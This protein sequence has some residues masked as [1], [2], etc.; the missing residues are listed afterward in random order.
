MGYSIAFLLCKLHLLLPHGYIDFCNDVLPPPLS[1][2]NS[3]MVSLLHFEFY[4]LYFFS[5]LLVTAYEKKQYLCL[6]PLTINFETLTTIL[7]LCKKHDEASDKHPFIF[8]VDCLI[9][10]TVPLFPI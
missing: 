2:Q 8:E 3:P 1:N 4:L 7:P 5:T 10:Q 9:F 6:L